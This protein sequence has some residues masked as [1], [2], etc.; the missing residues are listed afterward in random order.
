MKAYKTG[1]EVGEQKRDLK[2][3]LQRI[4]RAKS[5]KL[6]QRKKSTRNK[7]GQ[8]DNKSMKEAP[9][10]TKA[11]AESS[12]NVLVIYIKTVREILAIR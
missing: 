10:I 6:H 7:E 8:F 5:L 12:L 4:F 1:W 2:S 11:I 3:S 9:E